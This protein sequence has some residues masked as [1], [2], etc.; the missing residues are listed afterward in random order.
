MNVSPDRD[1][2]SMVPGGGAIHLYFSTHNQ[3]SLRFKLTQFS[4][5][6]MDMVTKK[7]GLSGCNVYFQQGYL[8]NYDV[9]RSETNFTCKCN[10]K[11][12]QTTKVNDIVQIFIFLVAAISFSSRKW[13][14][15]LIKIL[16]VV[17]LKIMKIYIPLILVGCVKNGIAY[18][19]SKF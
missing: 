3:F 17:R 12:V 15:R 7:Y 1:N 9:F 16:T 2:G 4:M 6:F 13:S 5:T 18:E 10:V 14:K 11:P 19:H 8:K